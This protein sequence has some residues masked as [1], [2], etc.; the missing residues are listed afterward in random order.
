M[1]GTKYPFALPNGVQLT[2]PNPLF[3]LDL[4]HA[5]T[6]F[7]IQ[8]CEIAFVDCKSALKYIEGFTYLLY[9]KRKL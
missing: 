4:H 6:T 5:P 3:A 2:E 1:S 8:H 9:K 7:P